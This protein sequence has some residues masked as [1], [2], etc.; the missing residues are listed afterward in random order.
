MA[1]VE[2]QN[3]RCALS[4][5]RLTP[6]MSSLDHK[7]PV[8]RGGSNDAENLQII[9]PVV[10][11]AKARMHNDEFIAMCHAIARAHPDTGCTSWHDRMVAS[12]SSE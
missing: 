10:N 11:Y 8:S 9:H 7:V 12:K 3:Y 2:G 1:I 6:E 5:V 4:G